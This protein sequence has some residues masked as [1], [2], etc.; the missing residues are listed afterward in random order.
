MKHDVRRLRVKPEIELVTRTG[1]EL[2]IARLRIET[3]AHDHDALGERGKLRI[4]ADGERDVGERPGG[5]DGHQMWVRAH[6]AN[7]KVRRIFIERLESGRPF[8]HRR[9][10]VGAHAVRD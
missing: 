4:D 8:G 7:E 9:N 3:A 2:G 5:V 6:L 1:S 10:Q